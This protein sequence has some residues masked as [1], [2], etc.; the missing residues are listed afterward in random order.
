M[1]SPAP[2]SASTMLKILRP[3]DPPPPTRYIDPDALKRELT[4]LIAADGGPDSARPRFIER[5]KEVIAAARKQAR[6]ELEADDLG[7][8]CAAGLSGFQDDLI[9]TLFDL[10][11]TYRCSEAER[12]EVEHMAIVATGG[13]GRGLL[14]P[15]SD[16][17]LLFLMP[18]SSSGKGEARACERLLY[19]LWDLG[20]KVGHA[21]RNPK[22]CV[23]LA[24]SDMTI[25]TSLI[26]ARLIL[27]NEMLFSELVQQFK[28]QFLKPNA[29]AF[30]DAKMAERDERHRSS[31][32]ARY[33]VEPNIKDG[34]GGLR[35]LHTLNWLS[36]AIYDA[37]VGEATI[38]AG[39]FTEEEVATF[40]R[41]EDFL[42]SVRC[43]LH[44][45]TGRPEERLTFDVQPRMAELLGYKRHGGLRA[46]ERFMKHYFL[47]A[48]DVGDLTGILCG[49]LEIQQLKS[50]PTLRSML[51]PLSW[52]VRRQVRTRTDF[53]I[54]N[55]RLNVADPGVFERDP[56]NI[57]RL[58][59]QAAQTG[60]FLH[61][62]AVRLLRQSGRLINRDVRENPE[63]NRI[64]LSLMT[65][66]ET[67]AL[68]LRRLNDAGVLGR[69]IPPFRRVVGMMQFNMYHHYTVDEHLIRTVEKLSDIERNETVDDLP[70]STRL[71]KTIKNR[72]VL[73]LAAFLHDIGKGR[74]ED[75]S[76]IGARIARELC[77]RLG[78]SPEE[79]DTV[80]WLVR[81]HLKMSNI[82]QRRDLADPRTIRNFAEI[83]KTPERLKLLLLLTVA[84]IR[85]VGPGTWN[86][87]KGQLL[88]TLYYETEVLLTGGHGKEARHE[89]VEKSQATL[90]EE[91]RKKGWTE[92]EI[93]KHYSRFFDDYWLR[94]D[95]DIH[96]KH[97]LFMRDAGTRGERLAFDQKTDAFTAVT[98]L[99]ILAPN[100]PRLLSLFAGAC[101]SVGANIVGAQISSTR[102]GFALDTFLLQREFTDDED[103]KR[104]CNRIRQSIERYLKG[105]ARV[106]KVLATRRSEHRV[107]AFS[108]VPKA[109][110]SNDLSDRYTVIEVTGRDRPGLLYELTSELSDLSLDISSAHIATFG[111]KVFDVFY[112][113]D[114][115]GRK[116]SSE[117]R[118][119]QISERLG[120]I[121]SIGEED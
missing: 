109:D 4:E 76:L 27:G 95:T 118:R 11:V 30:I 62:D 16:I 83:V 64:F 66:A 93:G 19:L 102:D 47:V 88:R 73:Y 45:L 99:T 3:A 94:F 53:R 113:T 23:K 91:L 44:F 2:G 35:D 31:G 85:A 9:R 63:A 12:H 28:T 72:T 43:F 67:A 10:I 84:D 6:K 121:V 68:S 39:V 106:Q 90:G 41:C 111:E 107:E 56:V 33:R 15:G 24:K 82:S 104:R 120:K 89:R 13:Y 50:A 42:W 116:V 18:G 86:G 110:V 5:V 80:E 78:L 98:E 34:K 108:V 21:T 48:K 79:T 87:W 103:E 105:E 49:A 52:Q 70:L 65:N 59:D 29:R 101:L 55:D 114:L 14:A 96:V 60:T 97:A 37:D 81:D 51:A 71:I 1:D 20:F 40:H 74:R 17:D 26:D 75:H 77:P 115:T 32:D 57:L 22:Q 54:D 8:R 36:K 58:F 25:A 117:R 69:F 38:R 100:H 92:P 61:P 7:R 46:V 119:E 112:V